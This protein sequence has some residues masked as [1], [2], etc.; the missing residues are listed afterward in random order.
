M[1]WV[2]WVALGAA[3]VMVVGVLYWFSPRTRSVVTITVPLNHTYGYQTRKKG[4]DQL[5]RY[6]LHKVKV[7]VTGPPGAVPLSVVHLRSLVE[8]HIGERYRY[9]ALVPERDLFRVDE[10]LRRESRTTSCSPEGV[11]LQW[12]RE[13]KPVL[14]RRRLQLSSVLVRVE[15][16]WWGYSQ[17]KAV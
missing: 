1:Q 4:E 10:E 9:S 3:L 2:N 5:Q 13:L 8:E 11:A 7:V 16:G 15:D 6:Q 17:G 14:R 12:Y